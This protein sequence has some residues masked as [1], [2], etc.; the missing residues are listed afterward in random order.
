VDRDYIVLSAMGPDKPGIVNQL[1][2]FLYD[3]GANIEDSRMAVLGEQFA[4]IL[5]A[6]GERGLEARLRP[7]LADIEQHTGLTVSMTRSQTRRVANSGMPCEVTAVALDHPG[8]IHSISHAVAR[9]GANIENLESSSAPAPLTGSPLF[10]LCMVCSLPESVP[11]ATFRSELEAVG[12]ELG[13]D[14]VVKLL[15]G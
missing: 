13:V 11:F 3:S 4:V 1:S 7:Q 8:I 12:L 5:L 10:T 6:S 15:Q 14:V 9:R 2:G